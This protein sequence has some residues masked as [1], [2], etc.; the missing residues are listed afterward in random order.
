MDSLTEFMMDNISNL[1]SCRK[2]AKSWRTHKTCGNQLKLQ[3]LKLQKTTYARCAGRKLQ[4]YLQWS[5]QR[6]PKQLVRA[7]IAVQNFNS[8]F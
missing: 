7:Q 5:G 2:I 1:T 4:I 6:N 8:F 3:K